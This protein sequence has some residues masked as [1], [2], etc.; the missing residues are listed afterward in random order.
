M[1]SVRVYVTLRRPHSLRYKFC[2]S[3]WFTLKIKIANLAMAITAVFFCQKIAPYF[4]VRFLQ[5]C[6]SEL[7][8]IREILK[9]AIS[10]SDQPRDVRGICHC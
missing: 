2:V 3:L 4:A 10:D 7:S 9:A 8:E 6:L 5:S 1:L